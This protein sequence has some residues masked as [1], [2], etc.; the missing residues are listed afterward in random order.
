MGTNLNPKGSTTLNVFYHEA[1]QYAVQD[2][3]LKYEK[4]EKVLQQCDPSLKG[5]IQ[6]MLDVMKHYDTRECVID[7]KVR[8]L[9]TGDSG[10]VLYGYHLDCCNDIWDDFEPETH[11]IYSTVIGTKFLLDPM[12]IDGYNSVQEVLENSEI[13]EYNAAPNWVHKYTSKV[14]HSSPRV[15]DDCQRI[16]IRVTAGFKDRIKHAKRKDQ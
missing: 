9:K 1:P 2:L 5:L 3:I 12:E 13:N 8:S 7:Y 11:L 4:P 6:K 15:E 10:S 14:L 16:L